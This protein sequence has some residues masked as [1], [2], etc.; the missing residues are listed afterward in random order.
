MGNLASVFRNWRRH[1]GSDIN[2]Q[3][4]MQWSSG[5]APVIQT[6]SFYI[7]GDTSTATECYVNGHGSAYDDDYVFDNRSFEVP[8]GVTI[9]FFQPHGFI[10]GAGISSLRNGRPDAD[11]SATDLEYAAGDQCANYILSKSHGRHL[12][13]DQAEAATWEMDYAGT[14]AVAGDM[15]L[16]IVT[17]RN[18]WFHAGVTLKSAISEVRAVAPGLAV[19]NCLFCRVTDDSTDDV[20][21]SAGGYWR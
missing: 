5:G 9:K 12:S 6:T 19:F 10:L 7:V 1:V 21:E 15:G 18:R 17:V 4:S 13:G 8:A 16:V 14:Q 3:P 20:W 11:A 2:K